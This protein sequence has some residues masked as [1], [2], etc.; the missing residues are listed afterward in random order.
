MT[1]IQIYKPNSYAIA[2][3][4]KGIGIYAETPKDLGK[5][6]SHL[7]GKLELI[8]EKPEFSTGREAWENEM[9]IVRANIEKT[10][11]SYNI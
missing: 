4:A 6:L 5:E 1:K 8:A 3:Y 2:A 10:I 9:S 7:K 11:A